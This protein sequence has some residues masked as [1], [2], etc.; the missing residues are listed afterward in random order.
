MTFKCAPR[1]SGRGLASHLIFGGTYVGIGMSKSKSNGSAL[2][3]FGGGNSEDLGL[4]P[5]I[6]TAG[7]IDGI[8]SS[9]WGP[10]KLIKHVFLM[11]TK[12]IH[13]NL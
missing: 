11:H 12:A 8:Y 1:G 6:L 2:T 5:R 4:F 7:W 9:L 10:W 13:T 3:T